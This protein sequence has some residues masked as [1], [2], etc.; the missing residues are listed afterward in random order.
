MSNADKETAEY[1]P[2]VRM[3]EWQFPPTVLIIEDDREFASFI[4]W[5]IGQNGYRTIHA[6]SLRDAV[7]VLQNEQCD[8]AILDLGLPDSGGLETFLRIVAQSAGVP[9]VILTD[10]REDDMLARRSIQLGAQD[11]LHK[12]TIDAVQLL[13]SVRH[14]IGRNQYLQKYVRS[15]NDAGFTTSFWIR[16][17]RKKIFLIDRGPESTAG[18]KSL[19]EEMGYDIQSTTGAPAA[20][21]AA[22]SWEP[23]IILTDLHPADD[24]GIEIVQNIRSHTSLEKV[25]ILMMAENADEASVMRALACGVNEFVTGPLQMG[26]IVLR[27]GKILEAGMQTAQLIETGRRFQKEKELLSRYFT[28]DLRESIINGTISPEL[29]G[30]RV[31]AT[32]MFFDLRASTRI[33]EQ[34]H[35]DVFSRLLSELLGDL[36]DLVESENGSINK[37]TGDGF[38]ATFGCLYED[39]QRA[40]RAVKCALR[41]REH[42]RLFNSFRPDELKV[43]LEFGI[44][45]ASGMVFAGNVGNHRLIEYAVLGDA[46]NLASRLEQ[47]TKKA[48]VDILVD[49]PTRDQLPTYEFKTMRMSSVRGKIAS[50][51]ICS[52][53][54][55][56]ALS[57]PV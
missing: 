36:I 21:D 33:A 52:P 51:D 54:G 55:Q 39:P 5:T 19:L 43:N 8:L 27:I 46:V 12:G 10:E 24:D 9:I 48:G 38:L 32:L 35:P 42:F 3:P 40:E 4:L 34:L 7:T 57:Q 18:L 44:G 30:K 20:I 25:P 47:L 53:L 28:D 1:A 13:R 50:V 29:G 16:K 31:D 6:S 23:D 49:G 17:G 14:A 2:T 45:I 22:S 41:I 15:F 26:E 56:K 37:F 11:F